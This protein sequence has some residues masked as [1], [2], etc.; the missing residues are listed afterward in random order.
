MVVEVCTLILSIWDP[1]FLGD[2]FSMGS[3]F[4]VF[5]AVNSVSFWMERVYQCIA[6]YCGSS[7][8]E[9]VERGRPGA[10]L[11]LVVV[12]EGRRACG[13]GDLHCL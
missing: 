10:G 2:I 13:G 7:V 3:S 4:P 12:G 8:Q 9:W 5:Y 11:L 6:A 1:L